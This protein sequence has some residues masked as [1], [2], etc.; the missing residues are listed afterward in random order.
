MD[1]HWTWSLPTSKGERGGKRGKWRHRPKPFQKKN[2]NP[3]SSVSP[4]PFLISSY[5]PSLVSPPFHPLT[6][7]TCLNPLPKAT[8]LQSDFPLEL[9]NPRQ[10]SW[11]RRKEC[12]RRVSKWVWWVCSAPVHPRIAAA[13]SS[14]CP[15]YD[16][17][18]TL[19][20]SWTT[21]FPR[22]PLFLACVPCFR[23][24]QE[25]CAGEKE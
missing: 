3:F 19:H 10:T 16:P 14:C 25:F 20:G 21:Y 7:F 4:F 17:P 13:A 12:K 9:V 6:K 23:G 8:Y 11:K 18:V 5:P 1:T 22:F 2:H 15:D 24:V